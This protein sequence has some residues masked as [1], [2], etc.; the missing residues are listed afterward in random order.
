MRHCLAAL[1]QLGQAVR[2]VN[3]QRR[4]QTFAIF[5]V[6]G[7]ITAFLSTMLPGLLNGMGNIKPCKKTFHIEK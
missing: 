5:G 3:E 1:R 6:R 4:S 7:F 2:L